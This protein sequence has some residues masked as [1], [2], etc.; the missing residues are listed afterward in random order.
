LVLVVPAETLDKTITVEQDKDTELVV[1]EATKPIALVVLAHKAL[2]MSCED[3]KK[4]KGICLN[5]LLLV[6]MQ[7]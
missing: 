2:F 5:S 7:L 6:M 4:G 3:S 1:A